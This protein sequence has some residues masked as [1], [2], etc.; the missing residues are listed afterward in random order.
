MVLAGYVVRAG[1][2]H[3]VAPPLSMLERVVQS[4][5]EETP[6]NQK[7]LPYT[8]EW[9]QATPTP[10]KTTTTNFCIGRAACARSTAIAV[11]SDFPAAAGH[12]K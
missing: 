5:T 8:G 10:S 11:M 9:K 2:A 3:A 12:A 4:K 7:I 1:D 6:F